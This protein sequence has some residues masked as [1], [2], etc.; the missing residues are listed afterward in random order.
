MRRHIPAELN[1]HETLVWNM[2]Y[3]AASDERELLR[4]ALER[5]EYAVSHLRSLTPEGVRTQMNTFALAALDVALEDALRTL[6]QLPC[7][8]A[9]GETEGTRL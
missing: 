8:D 1:E 3:N 6:G 2:G 9:E 5:L 4:G 7:A